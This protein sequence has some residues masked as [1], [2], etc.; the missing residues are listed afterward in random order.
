MAFVGFAKAFDNIEILST[1]EALGKRINIDT[2]ILHITY[3]K[4]WK[5]QKKTRNYK[6]FG[7]L[8]NVNVIKNY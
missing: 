1:K 7:L 8:G 4:M 5:S 3:K 6:Y 2:D